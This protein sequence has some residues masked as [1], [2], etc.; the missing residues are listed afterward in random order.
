MDV[1][2][3]SVLKPLHPDASSSAVIDLAH[4]R[5][6]KFQERRKNNERILFN[7]LLSVYLLTAPTLMRPVRLI[8][9]STEGCSFEAPPWDPQSGEDA[10]SGATLRLYFSPTTYLEITLSIKSSTTVLESRGRARRFGCLIDPQQRSYG[11]YQ[12]F[13]KF[14]QAYSSQALSDRGDVRISQF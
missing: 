12:S 2:N 9:V 10:S 11:A 1:D 6:K 3:E 4:F 14:L 8:E 5:E 7:N 13:V